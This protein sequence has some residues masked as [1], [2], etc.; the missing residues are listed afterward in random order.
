MAVFTLRKLKLDEWALCDGPAAGPCADVKAGA[1]GIR[2]V[3][4]GTAATST[5]PAHDRRKSDAK[6]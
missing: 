5:E 1:L 6:P 3:P 2:A 4:K